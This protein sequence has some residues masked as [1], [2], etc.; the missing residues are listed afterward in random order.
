MKRISVIATFLVIGMSAAW[1]QPKLHLK[2]I[3]GVHANTYITKLDTLQADV[4]GGFQFGFG[5]RV[6]MKKKFMAEF[7]LLWLRQLFELKDPVILEQF[8]LSQMFLRWHSFEIPLTAGYVPVYSPFYKLYLYGGVS[9]YFNIKGEAEFTFADT[10][11]VLTAK[12]R[13][14]DVD[15]AAPIVAARMGIQ[16]DIAFFNM[17]FNYNIGMNSATKTNFRT[18]MHLLQL[19]IGFVF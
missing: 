12:I 11:E 18:Q 5:A 9:T 6:T 16:M 19:N 17:D 10:G 1:A 13:N 3:G 7:D 15:F 8:G 14:K 4:G 2:A